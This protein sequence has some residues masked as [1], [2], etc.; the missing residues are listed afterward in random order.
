MPAIYRRGTDKVL[1]FGRDLHL[2]LEVLIQWVARASDASFLSIAYF[3]VKL[4]FSF[5]SFLP[6]LLSFKF[7]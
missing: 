7:V 5:R 2:N 3:K 6:Y 4:F 1:N